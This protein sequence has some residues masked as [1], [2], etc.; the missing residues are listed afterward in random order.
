MDWTAIKEQYETQEPQVSTMDWSGIS[1]K[2]KKP[3]P[4]LSPA[5]KYASMVQPDE[6]IDPKLAGVEVLKRQPK[7]PLITQRLADTK[8]P[9]QIIAGA[10]GMGQGMLGIPQL[11]AGKEASEAAEKIASEHKAVS[12]PAELGGALLT[13]AVGGGLTNG[14]AP[15]L[16]QIY[17]ESPRLARFI[18]RAVQAATTFS[19]YNLL[20]ESLKQMREGSFDSNKLIDETGKGYIFGLGIGGLGGIAGTAK[21]IISSG[22][23]AGTITALNQKLETG[24]VKPVDVLFNTALA[25]GFTA[26]N[27][28][29]VS[30]NIRANALNELEQATKERL[31]RENPSLS[32]EIAGKAAR[33]FRNAFEVEVVKKGGRLATT[34]EI[35]DFTQMIAK[36][37]RLYVEAPTATPAETV[38][39]PEIIKIVSNEFVSSPETEAM[40][41]A[42]PDI[43]KPPTMPPPTPQALPMPT[44]LPKPNFP[45]PEGE[46]IEIPPT[47]QEWNNLKLNK[48]LQEADKSFQPKFDKVRQQ[49]GIWAKMRGKVYI[50]SLEANGFNA[51]VLHKEYGIPYAF[52]NTDPLKSQSLDS[53]AN[54]NRAL[55]GVT[56]ENVPMAEIAIEAL[57]DYRM[58][59]EE[60]DPLKRAVTE[61]EK[62]GIIELLG[63]LEEIK[64]E[65][66]RKYGE[67]TGSRLA[68]QIQKEVDATESNTNIQRTIA[69]LTEEEIRTIANFL[70]TPTADATEPK[71][72]TQ[73]GMEHRPTKTSP[74]YDLTKDGAIPEDI[75][76]HPEYYAD[77]QDPIYRQS[78]AAIQNAKGKPNATITIYRSSPKKELNEGDWVTLSREYA[79]QEGK[80]PS[81][82]KQDLPVHS[83]KVKAKDVF[84]AGDDINEFGYFGKPIIQTSEQIKA[85]IEKE[86]KYILKHGETPQGADIQGFRKS[87]FFGKYGTSEKKQASAYYEYLDRQE[88]APVLPQEKQANKG[89]AITNQGIVVD[90]PDYNPHNLSNYTIK[91]KKISIDIHPNKNGLYDIYIEDDSDPTF[92]DFTYEEAIE[93]A[94]SEIVDRETSLKWEAEKNQFIDSEIQKIKLPADATIKNFYPTA[95]GSWYIEIEQALPDE[96]SRIIK[97]RISDH[98]PSPF[99]EQEFGIVDIEIQKGGNIREWGKEEWQ[100]AINRLERAIN[101]IESPSRAETPKGAEQS[102]QDIPSTKTGENIISN[103]VK[104]VKP[105]TESAKTTSNKAVLTIG[106][107]VSVKGM[108]KPV[109]IENIRTETDMTGREYGINIFREETLPGGL[110]EG[111]TK[112]KE[113]LFDYGQ[114]KEG[115]G[116]VQGSSGKTNANKPRRYYREIY[117][118]K[119]PKTAPKT[120]QELD[121]F[122]ASTFAPIRKSRSEEFFLAIF[123]KNR[124]PVIP[125]KELTAEQALEQ[126]KAQRK[127][128]SDVQTLGLEPDMFREETLPDGLKEGK[129]KIKEDLYGKGQL[130]EEYGIPTPEGGTEESSVTKRVPRRYYKEFQRLPAPQEK[131]QSIEELD[132][133][134][135]QVFSSIRKSR[136]EEV[137]LVLTDDKYNVIKAIFVTRGK[138]SSA[139]PDIVEII[140]SILN[141][142]NVD[143]AHIIHNHPSGKPEFSESD[144]NFSNY[145]GKKVEIPVRSMAIAGTEY[146]VTN[147]FFAFLPHEVSKIKLFLKTESIPIHKTYIR[148]IGKDVIAVNQFNIF[149]VFKD[150]PE[151]FIAIDSQSRVLDKQNLDF[152]L[153]QAGN[154]KENIFKDIIR[155]LEL[156]GSD[157]CSPQTWG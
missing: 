17:R 63:E 138:V 66:R 49:Q 70:A 25:A 74:V 114:E 115:K 28:P 125:K 83:F 4:V 121:D 39:K 24:E 14:I 21:R 53:W 90:D 3:Q 59:A 137:Y 92:K 95:N 30:K 96:E 6:N 36:G 140:G 48:E 8:L 1:K 130:S 42:A 7:V 79:K 151:G 127:A 101:R 106:D 45:T 124:K 155:C 56:D 15:A 113:D 34:R 128:E 46:P 146:V 107:E 110:K 153:N 80:H 144:V 5:A 132:N 62:E 64:E 149:G 43:T 111:T 136:S 19:S 69:S 38:I 2:F 72:V 91:G 40:R 148:P 55:L 98:E 103:R 104:D 143:Q 78:F 141:T 82:P 123:D 47:P 86:K 57:K 27:A 154:V 41:A 112:V 88:K 60:A 139:S 134:L 31:L 81:D 51:D 131:P 147:P 129:T 102:F 61:P 10:Y 35:E 116:T 68:T 54:E 67:E 50:G 13:I 108:E 109:K 100:D 58:N 97:A 16:S 118:I 11:M 87:E 157:S 145:I 32:S 85:E 18:P 44:P 77:M 99:R 126:M 37:W 152:N 119:T 22:A 156:A 142:P 26:I 120:T 150:I 65:I 33:S 135:A 29:Q 94:K 76:T 75:Y 12:M 93:T 71:K 122:V 23:F 84:F 133:Y 73:Y 9:E 105:P 20:K 52:W 89:I 117:S